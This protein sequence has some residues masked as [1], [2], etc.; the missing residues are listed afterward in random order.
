VSRAITKRRS[1]AGRQASRILPQ[2]RLSGP[3]PW[4][5]AIMIALTV[6]AVAGGLALGNL[7]GNSRAEIA[8][9]V[10]VQIVE[11]APQE[12]D[13]QAETALAIL[14]NRDDVVEARRVPDAEIAALLEPWLGD[15]ESEE[16][17][18]PTPALIDLRLRGVVDETRLADLRAALV[19]EAPSARVDGQASW[20][21][22]ALEA[23]A[24]L[25][26][27]ALGLVL[28]LAATSVAAV[29]LAARNAL[30][31][32]RTTID[33]IH[34]LGA[35]DSQIAGIFQRS[36]ALDALAGGTAGL[37]VGLG[38]I[39]LL[40]RQFAGLGSALVA[41]GGLTQMDW[42]IIAT[43]PILGVILAVVTARMTIISALRQIL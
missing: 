40:G 41:G 12:R 33:V 22:P 9:G 6:V 30:G 7:A 21:A 35:T 32:N 16:D 31:T 37:L 8:G 18:I 10:T 26:Y 29:W 25:Q 1:Q 13:R 3:V 17:A 20:L 14:G 23:I 15:V 43:I 39:L 11:G 36:V 38:A 28:L 34:H 42:I 2:A 24:S 5:I 4:V 19:Q 27:L